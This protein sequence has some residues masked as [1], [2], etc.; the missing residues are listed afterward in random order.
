MRLSPGGV[1]SSSAAMQLV[2]SGSAEMGATGLPDALRAIDKGADVAI[3]RIESGPAPYEL[4]AKPQIKT[5]ADL[6]GKT[7]MIGGI[8]DTLRGK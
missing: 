2:A 8:K 3:I 7:I 5:F 1:Q 4:Y 6:R